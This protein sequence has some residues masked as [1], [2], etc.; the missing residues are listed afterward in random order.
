MV[1][2]SVSQ[3]FLRLPNICMGRHGDDGVGQQLELAAFGARAAQRKQR[4]LVCIVIATFLQDL[5][6][7]GTAR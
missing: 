4:R 3:S 7:W 1:R 6:T 5:A 2:I